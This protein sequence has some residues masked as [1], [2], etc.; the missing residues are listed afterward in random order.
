MSK[1]EN[2]TKLCQTCKHGKM[3]YYY[4]RHRE[5]GV[6][7]NIPSGKTQ[8]AKPKYKG[9]TYHVKDKTDCP[10]YEKRQRENEVK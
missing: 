4:E 1:S 7:S 10:D 2:Q 3:L 6:R 5:T 9:R 8:C